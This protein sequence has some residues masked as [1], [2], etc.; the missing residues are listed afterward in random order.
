MSV[1]G[2]MCASSCALPRDG[3]DDGSCGVPILNGFR[4]KVEIVGDILMDGQ[5]ILSGL[6]EGQAS[7]SVRDGGMDPAV[8]ARFTAH[9]RQFELLLDM[10]RAQTTVIASFA[11]DRP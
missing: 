7:D 5:Q 9:N 10:M 1:G 3:S 4:S 6:E 8:A 11:A 2:R